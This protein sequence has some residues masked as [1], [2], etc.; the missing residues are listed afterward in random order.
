MK[1]I[2]FII[3]GGSS[4][5]EISDF[6]RDPSWRNQTNGVPFWWCPWIHDLE[7]MVQ[8]A[9]HGLGSIPT[10]LASEQQHMIRKHIQEIFV[11]GHSPVLPRAVLNSASQEEIDY[12]IGEQAK[13]FPSA[14]IVEHRLALISSS[15]TA[16]KS[17]QYDSIPMFDKG[18][19]F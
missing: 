2:R 7:L 6:L 10:A 15:L 12:W 3:G 17:A 11:Q 1:S 8:C 18:G 16:G 4:L 13:Q 9:L 14:D 19:R 5:K